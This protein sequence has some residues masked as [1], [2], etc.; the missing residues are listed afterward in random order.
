MRSALISHQ[1]WGTIMTSD[2]SSAARPNEAPMADAVAYFL[3]WTTYGTWL[4]GDDRGWVLKGSGFQPP[5]PVL[6][7]LSADRMTESACTLDEYARRI[8]EET[9]RDHCRRRDWELHAVNCRSNH[10]HVVV[11][12]N[13]SAKKVREELKA[14]CTRKLKE[15]SGER[16]TRKH[17]WTEGGSRRKIGDQESL[18]AVIHYVL[19]A[20]D[21]PSPKRQRGTRA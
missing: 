17:W 3:T 4:P 1:T 19:Y 21:D 18:E 7:K 9:I 15:A 6:Q 16:I 10:V 11:T 5:R 14:R 8:V 13:V 12:A 20:Q 2:V